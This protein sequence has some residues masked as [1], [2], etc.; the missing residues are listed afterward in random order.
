MTDKPA[1]IIDEIEHVDGRVPKW[2]RH[3]FAMLFVFCPFY[4]IFYHTG[5]PGRSMEE[6]YEKALAENTRLQF[7]EIGELN[8]DAATVLQYTGKDSWLKVGKVLFKANCATC[9][10]REGQGLVGPNLTDDT[11]KNVRS[12][13]DVATV[14]LKGANN[15]AMPAWEGK[16]HPN[17]IVFVSAYVASLRGTDVAGGK[18]AEGIQIPEWPPVPLESAKTPADPELTDATNDQD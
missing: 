8:A 10:G 18:A 2:W 12:I 9:H 13:G 7:A 4:M 14:I 5:A 3:T 17:E 1:L 6:R 15:N 11:Y 16:L